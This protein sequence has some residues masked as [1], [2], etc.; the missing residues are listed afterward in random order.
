M[1]TNRFS[2]RPF[3][4]YA[5]AALTS[6]LAA[7]AAHAA[8]GAGAANTFFT[9]DADTGFIVDHNQRLVGGA[10]TTFASVDTNDSRGEA[11]ML[12]DVT[13]DSPVL[14]AFGSTVVPDGQAI[15][16]GTGVMA[17]RF[18]GPDDTLFTYDVTLTGELIAAD[19]VA[20]LSAIARLLDDDAT[21]LSM[22]PDPGSGS[23]GDPSDL[24]FSDQITSDALFFNSADT[25]GTIEETFRLSTRVD[26]GDVIHLGLSLTATAI[27]TGAVADGYSTLTGIAAVD[28]GSLTTLP[29]PEPGS[30]VAGLLAGAAL[31]RR[32]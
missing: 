32:R 10:D 18:D 11:R 27:G 12:V 17:V 8:F 15:G 25:V 28:A 24:R 3:R 6:A 19:G 14:R 23:S 29:V 20:R 9:L 30:A 13:G 4:T 22:F 2:N 7:P 16:G 5:A 26:N 1:Q 31:L 21:Y